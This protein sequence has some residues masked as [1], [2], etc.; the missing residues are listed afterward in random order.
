MTPFCLSS[1]ICKPLII[2][3]FV[4]AGIFMIVRA[5]FAGIY[6]SQSFGILDQFRLGR[7]ARYDTNLGLSRILSVQYFL[8]MLFSWLSIVASQL[9]LG[10]YIKIYVEQNGAQA[11]PAQVWEVF[12]KYFF[13]VFFFSIPLAVLILIGYCFCIVPGV[14]LTVV[15]V[16][17]NLILMVEDLSFGDAFSRCF[18]IIRDNFWISLAVYLVAGIIYVFGGLIVSAAV[19]AVVG[20]S[21]FFTTRS[22]GTTLGIV[23][24]ILNIFS[25]FFYI[26]F[27]VSMALQYY[28]L[29][30]IHDGTGL[31]GRIDEIGGGQPLSSNAPEEY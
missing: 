15:L 11:T 13:R 30:E 20:I 17:Y 25:G 27:F 31:L 22:L 21:A 16:P 18:S 7:S 28:N 3:F 1:K 8:L 10:A 6:Q 5:I 9:A 2:S 4:I 24:S 26:I 14:W 19:G 23:T 12:K 29:V